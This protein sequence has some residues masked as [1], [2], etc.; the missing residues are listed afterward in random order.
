MR[1]KDF[2]IKQALNAK[3]RD[4]EDWRLLLEGTDPCLRLSSVMR[5]PGAL[6]SILEVV[7]VG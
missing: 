1:Q 5:P 7:K 3:E 2:M 6:H 4:A